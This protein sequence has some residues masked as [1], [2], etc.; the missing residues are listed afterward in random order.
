MLS[1][2]L[3]D[4]DHVLLGE[5][6]QQL[7]LLLT[8]EPALLAGEHLVFLL[9]FFRLDVDGRDTPHRR[10]TWWVIFVGTLWGHLWGTGGCS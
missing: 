3:V 1:F 5:M 6:L 4:P 2:L 7:L 10:G 9:D 8:S